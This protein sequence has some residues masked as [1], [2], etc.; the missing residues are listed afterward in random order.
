M[1]CIVNTTYNK[2][3]NNIEQMTIQY[4]DDST[5]MIS[6]NN[7]V[8]LEKYIEE[9]FKL[10]EIYYSINKLTLNQDKMKFMIVYK[11]NKI[12]AC[13]DSKLHLYRSQI[14]DDCM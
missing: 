6:H 10:I 4:V 8:E 12:L 7:I 1:V 11:G 13:I 14:L 3:Y 9:L 2:N 5:N